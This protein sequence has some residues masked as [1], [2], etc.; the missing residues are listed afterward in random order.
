MDLFIYLAKGV[1]GCKEFKNPLLKGCQ[2]WVLSQSF[3]MGIVLK[4]EKIGIGAR[5]WSTYNL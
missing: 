2:Y 1:P 4:I 3:D 5:L